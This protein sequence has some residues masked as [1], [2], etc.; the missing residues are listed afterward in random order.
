MHIQQIENFHGWQIN[1]I[2]A[3]NGMDVILA[4]C[5]MAETKHDLFVAVCRKGSKRQAEQDCHPKKGTFK[6]LL[7][8]LSFFRL[9]TQLLP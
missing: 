1:G 2:V 3:V 8:R 5:R 6:K 4:Y 7:H 9:D